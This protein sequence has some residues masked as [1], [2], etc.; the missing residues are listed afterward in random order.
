MKIQQKKY[1]KNYQN[2]NYIKQVKNITASREFE[3]KSE[4]GEL[5]ITGISNW[6]HINLKS[7]KIEKVTDQLIDAYQLEPEKTNFN[8]RKL[9]KLKEPETYLNCI[10]YKIDLNWIDVN[11]HM[12]NIYYLELADMILPEEVRKSNNCSNFEIMYKKEIKYGDII[13][14]YYAEPE[15]TS[16][17]VTLKNAETGEIC[18]IIKL[19]IQKT[20]CKKLT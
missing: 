19:Y 8:E 7:K 20:S 4:E 2:K 3:I 9:K 17:V 16:H 5:L 10:D 18:A 11:N 12:N 14:C 13:K 6:V 15:N 1:Q